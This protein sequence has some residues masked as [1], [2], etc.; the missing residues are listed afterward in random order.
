V[1]EFF[2]DAVDGSSTRRASAE[3]VGGMNRPGFAG[4]HLV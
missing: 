4:G 2:V 3:D 1:H